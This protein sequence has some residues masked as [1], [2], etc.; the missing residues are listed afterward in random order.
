[1]VSKNAFWCKPKHHIMNSS[2]QKIGVKGF[3]WGQ[4][5]YQIRTLH[6]SYK[7]NG[8]GVAGTESSQKGQRQ[9]IKYL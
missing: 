9:P 7:E 8:S 5:F 4:N 6:F 2:V 3:V 1:M